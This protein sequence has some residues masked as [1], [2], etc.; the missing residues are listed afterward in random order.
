MDM[1]SSVEFVL[2]QQF[3]HSLPAVLKPYHPVIQTLLDGMRDIICNRT[4]CKRMQKVLL[5]AITPLA[6]FSVGRISTVEGL[7]SDLKEC[8]RILKECAPSSTASYVKPVSVCN[9]SLS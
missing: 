3:I 6:K 5:E 4:V 1:P 2:V 8:E 9:A 7:E